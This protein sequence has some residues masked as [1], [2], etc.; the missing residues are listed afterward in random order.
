MHVAGQGGVAWSLGRLPASVT[1]VVVLIQP[2]VAAILGWVIFKEA[3]TTIQMIGGAVV[4]AGIVLAQRAGVAQTKTG[5]E[6]KAPAPE[7][8]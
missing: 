2:V 8:S 6:A 7:N 3:M 4:L 5:A 1:A